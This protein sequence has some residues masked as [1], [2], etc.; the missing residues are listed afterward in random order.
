MARQ[1]TSLTA[2]QIKNAKPREKKYKLFDGGGLFLQINSNGSK[3][4]RLKYRMN[5][6][7]SK[8]SKFI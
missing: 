4:W 8:C 1:T 6:S 3:L 5:G 2:T 7:N